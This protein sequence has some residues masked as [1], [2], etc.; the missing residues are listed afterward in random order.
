MESTGF[1]E[2]REEPR[3]QW[4]LVYDRRTG[5]VVHIHQFIAAAPDGVVSPERLASQ[6]IE[7]ASKRQ[8]QEFLEVAYPDDV[9]LDINARYRVDPASG[10]VTSETVLR[11][12]PRQ[13]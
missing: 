8:G 5:A 10:R 11:S 1:G 4:C 12:Q 7:Q 13:T 9:S 2:D 3:T 6:A